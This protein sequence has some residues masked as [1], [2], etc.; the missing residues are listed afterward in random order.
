MADTILLDKARSADIDELM[1]WFGD[2]SSTAIWGGPKFRYPFTKETFH[3]DCLWNNMATYVVRGTGRSIVAFGQLYE[4]YGRINLAR[5]AVNPECRGE[6]LGR[7][8][9]TLLI[10]KGRETFDLGEYSLFVRTD[11]EI[12]FRLYS[13]MG[14]SRSEYPRDAPMQDICYFMTRPLASEREIPE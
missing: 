1:T 7:V 11:N 9:M 13:S 8:L 12:A 10:D 6:G 5:L 2:E 3:A 4:R 14:F